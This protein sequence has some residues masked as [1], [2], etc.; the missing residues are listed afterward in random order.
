MLLVNASK[1]WIPEMDLNDRNHTLFNVFFV[2][3]ISRTSSLDAAQTPC[4]NGNT[5]RKST[6]RGWS[7][8][9]QSSLF[10]NIR[11]IPGRK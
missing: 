2:M 11:S 4:L 8:N 7:R 5:S 3:D 1:L 6:I 9:S 10:G